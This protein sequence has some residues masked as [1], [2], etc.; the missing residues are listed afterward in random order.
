MDETHYHKPCVRKIFASIQKNTLTP[1]D[2]T[3]MKD[4][5]S[6]DLLRRAEWD[7]AEQQGIMKG[8][9][10]GREEGREEGAKIK[11]L[12]IASNLLDVLDDATIAKKTGLTVV[13]I[14]NLRQ[15]KR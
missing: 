7:K 10:K 8:I 15:E 14:S 12:D 2:R 1:E 13:E 4:E 3:R 9:A 6:E 5:Y 11:A